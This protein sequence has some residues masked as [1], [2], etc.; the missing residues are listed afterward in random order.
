[1]IKCISFLILSLFSLGH[2]YGGKMNSYAL[3]SVTSITPKDATTTNALSVTYEVVFAQSVTGVDASDFTLTATEALGASITGVIGSATTYIVTIN[4]GSGNGNIRLDFSGLAGTIPNVNTEF[5]TASAYLIYK[6]S[7]P[8]DHFRCVS[9]DATWTTPGDWESSVDSSFWITATFPPGASTAST[10][11]SEG[12]NMW[13]TNGQVDVKNLINNGVMNS[14]YGQIGIYLNSFANNGTIRGSAIFLINLFKNAGTL[15]PDSEHGTIGSLAFASDMITF[16]DIQLEIGGT[17]M[18]LDYDNI[19]TSGFTAGGT[20]SVSLING[21]T[22]QLGDSFALV[23]AASITGKFDTVNLPDIAPLFWRTTSDNGNYI[24]TVVDEVM[25]VTLINFS[26]T[27]NESAVDLVWSTSS[28]L[29]SSYFE[30]QRSLQGK[31]WDTIGTINAHNES[32]EI[33]HYRFTDPFP[34]QHENLYRLRMVDTDG[35]F[36]FSKIERVRL[37]NVVNQIKNYPNPV[38]DRIFLDVANPGSVHSVQIYSISGAVHY[39]GDY[40]SAGINVKAMPPGIFILKMTNADRT[41]S[42][43]KFVK[44]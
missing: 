20:L 3:T 38:T 23:M 36:S 22:P 10:V 2:S 27:K 37:A 32:L 44:H 31:T 40:T 19:Q 1:M 18:F 9:A 17:R 14:A 16:G 25:P 4:T 26:A 15:A 33:Q 42:I 41:I 24:V 30:I 34:M 8:S 12:Q 35:S 43:R 28:E 21:F 5:N 11:I 39:T 7:N 6:V 13:M 29:N